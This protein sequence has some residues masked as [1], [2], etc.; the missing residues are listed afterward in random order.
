MEDV[1]RHHDAMP[2]GDDAEMRVW[3]E[4]WAHHRHVEVMRGQFLGF[5]FTAVLGVTAIAGPGLADDSLRSA[6]S[7]L[8][9][10]ALAIGLQVLAGFLYLAVVRLNVVLGYYHDLIHD[11]GGS[12]DTSPAVAAR[13][14]AG[15]P[16]P[17]R[18][19]AGTSGVTQLVLALGLVLFPLVLAATV[20]RSADLTG[21]S[22][23]TTLC[24]AAFVASLATVALVRLG[25]GNRASRLRG[26]AALE[27]AAS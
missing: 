19:W 25:V 9:L 1:V 15:P 13:L 16:D 22:T 27:D 8:I 7:L 21:M 17:P 24:V 23:T 3:D 11:L 12:M 4:A 20:A 18:R 14:A 5:F 10:A 6:G 26:R 2:S